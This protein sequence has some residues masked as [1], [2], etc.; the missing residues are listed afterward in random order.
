[1]NNSS[2]HKAIIIW[3]SFII[4]MVFAMVFIGGVTRLT[5][6]GLSM[7]DWKPIMG[8][9]PPLTQSEW[10]A[11]FLKYQA[12]P[13]FNKVNFHM[14]LT[15]YIPLGQEIFQ[16]LDILY[17]LFFPFPFFSELITGTP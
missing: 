13:E 3:L 4:V 14:N 12:Y 8:A 1:M 16:W 17:H 6:S 10:Q 2:E 5:D 9:I 15:F 7:V 11:A